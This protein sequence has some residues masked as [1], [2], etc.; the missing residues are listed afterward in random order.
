[1]TVFLL[2]KTT[3]RGHCPQGGRVPFFFKKEHD[4]DRIA[5]VS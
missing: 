3:L 5:P 2:Q 4:N 1:M